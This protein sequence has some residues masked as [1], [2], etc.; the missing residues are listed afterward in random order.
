LDLRIGSGGFFFCMC[1]GREI[2]FG[3]RAGEATAGRRFAQSSWATGRAPG[4]LGFRP[5]S[6][7]SVAVVG[8]RSQDGGRDG[9][10]PPPLGAKV[11]GQDVFVP[12]RG[13]R[14]GGAGGGPKAGSLGT[15]R[16]GGGQEKK[17]GGG[18]NPL[19][20]G[21][22]WCAC[23]LTRVKGNGTGTNRIFRGPT[24]WASVGVGLRIIVG[25]DQ[26]VCGI[27]GGAAFRRARATGFA[28]GGRTN[29]RGLPWCSVHRGK[30]DDRGG[31]FKRPVGAFEAGGGQQTRGGAGTAFL[32]GGNPCLR[33]RKTGGG[34]GGVNSGFWVVFVGGFL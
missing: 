31:P 17:T 29:T 18:H 6:H 13:K 4:R 23:W 11:S 16:G 5:G 8:C 33:G 26:Q 19:G 10:G 7:G 30:D 28:C 14:Y 25:G 22:F 1:F 24:L 12:R 2:C 20:A 9:G 21:F 32:N 34:E 15:A 3:S 27:F